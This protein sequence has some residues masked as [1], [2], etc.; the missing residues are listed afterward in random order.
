M[1]KDFT[2]DPKLLTKYLE[3]VNDFPKAYKNGI[4][5]CFAGSHGLG[6]TLSVTSIIK[7]ASLKGYYC[8]Y[9]TLSDIVSALLSHDN[10]GKSLAR[11]ELIS[12]DFLVIDEFDSRFMATES[13]SDL[14][15]RTLEGVFRTRS[16]NC[17]PTLMCTNSPN[18]VE[19]FS[20][21]IKESLGSLMKGYV[22]NVIVLGEDFRRANPSPT[23]HAEP[24]PGGGFIKHGS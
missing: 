16:Q 1:D 23:K 17:L 14:F 9:T 21:P 19:S 20:G 22:R 12:V 2:G 6:K 8:L 18:P 10:E 24:I 11:R 13:A 15:G 4:A 7:K 5:L 3:I